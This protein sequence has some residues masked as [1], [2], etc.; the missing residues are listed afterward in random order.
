MLA[1]DDLVPHKDT[2][3]EH[4]KQREQRIQRYHGLA[5]EGIGKNN[6]HEERDCGFLYNSARND[7][8]L[9]VHSFQK[10]VIL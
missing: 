9:I 10:D 7:L 8:Y 5:R 1:E 3:G 6:M 2:G 4:S